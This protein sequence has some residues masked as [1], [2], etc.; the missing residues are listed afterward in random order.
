ML[1]TCE[2]RCICVDILYTYDDCFVESGLSLH[3]C[4]LDLPSSYVSR[5]FCSI[6]RNGCLAYHVR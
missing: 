3:D 2:A 5:S 1:L 6:S 4:G